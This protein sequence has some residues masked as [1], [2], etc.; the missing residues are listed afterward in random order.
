MKISKIEVC[1]LEDKVEKEAFE[2][3][4]DEVTF[5]LTV[6]RWKSTFLMFSK[7]RFGE[8]SREKIR[9]VRAVLL[10][11]PKPHQFQHKLQF[12]QFSVF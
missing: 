12:F 10:D 5:Q 3:F 7:T 11:T 4:C 9:M 1:V 2:T 6:G 8:T